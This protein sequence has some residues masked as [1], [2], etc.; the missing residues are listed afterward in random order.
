MKFFLTIVSLA[1]GL[2]AAQS[3]DEIPECA[4]PC[5]TDAV[6]SATTCSLDDYKCWCTTDNE[7]AI[8]QA[9]TACVLAACGS[10]VA[11]NDVLPA[12]QQF[13]EEVNAS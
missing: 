6:T 3:L 13:C 9:G 2:V 8:V 4:Q 5:I 1:A 7:S 10:D 12:V 11:V